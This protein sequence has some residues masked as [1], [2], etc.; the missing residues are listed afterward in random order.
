MFARSR[1]HDHMEESSR[2]VKIVF[3]HTGPS[4]DRLP[5]TRPKCLR[6]HRD[7]FQHSR[8]IILRTV[9]TRT[10]RPD[11][12]FHWPDTGPESLPGSADKPVS[13]RENLVHLQSACLS[14][15]HVA[16]TFDTSVPVQKLFRSGRE[17]YSLKVISTPARGFYAPL[18]LKRRP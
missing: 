5:G 16:I 4:V 15:V 17:Y 14:A 8:S 10:D 11:P 1:G 18:Q 9:H 2:S 3:F 7:R 6:V 12:S 13:N